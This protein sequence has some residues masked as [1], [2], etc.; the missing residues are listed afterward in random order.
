[1]EKNARY[2]EMADAIL[3]PSEN[4]FWI[5]AIMFSLTNLAEC[6]LFLNTWIPMLVHKQKYKHKHKHKHRQKH[7]HKYKY[8]YK[9]KCKAR[10]KQKKTKENERKGKRKGKGKERETN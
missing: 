7:K 2:S 3:N 6:H 5:F 9:Y 1:L 10:F 4:V 8:K